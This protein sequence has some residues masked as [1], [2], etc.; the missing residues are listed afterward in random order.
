MENRKIEE[1]VR[2]ILKA[3]NVVKAPVPIVEIAEN[4]G[5]L[6]IEKVMEDDESGFLIYSKNG[7]LYNEKKYNKIIA[8]NTSENPLRKRFTIAHELG[9]YFLEIHEKE[10]TIPY[11]YVHREQIIDDYKKERE[12]DKFASEL[13][14]PI[15][16]LKYE[17]RNI[18]NVDLLFSDIPRFISNKFQVSYSAAKIK[19]DEYSRRQR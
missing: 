11:Y 12:A 3:C 17:L 16:F 15:D 7:L 14:M 2:E 9:H 1:L 10:D 18:K 5:F 4:Y 6:V 19:F 13:L 8:I